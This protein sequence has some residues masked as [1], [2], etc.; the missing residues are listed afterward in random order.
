MI[1]GAYILPKIITVVQ[2][3]LLTGLY[4][5][6]CKDSYPS[7]IRGRAYIRFVSG[8]ESHIY[9]FTRTFAVVHI[10]SFKVVTAFCIK[11]QIFADLDAIVAC[12][13]RILFLIDRFAAVSRHKLPFLHVFQ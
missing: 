12:A 4:V 9:L 2:V 8:R 1:S 6:R 3:Q 5:P 13:C 11:I 10:S 7:E